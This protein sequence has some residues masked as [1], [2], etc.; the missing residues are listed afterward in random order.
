M[1]PKKRLSVFVVVCVLVMILFILFSTPLFTRTR[2]SFD[3][4][5]ANGNTFGQMGPMTPG[6]HDYFVINISATNTGS[7]QNPV[8]TAEIKW[9]PENTE[10]FQVI[11]RQNFK[12]F[13]DGFS[14]NYYIPIGENKYWVTAQN[15]RAVP[16]ATNDIVVNNIM[17]E[18]PQIEGIDFYVGR[19]ELKS[20]TFFPIDI[21]FNLQVKGLLG[22]QP[23][24]P[25][26]RYLGPSYIFL[27]SLLII[28][29]IFQL[30]FKNYLRQMPVSFGRKGISTLS[31]GRI[32]IVVSTAIL[33]LFSF[34]FLSLQA[35]TIKSYWDSYK[36]YI[37][38]GDLDKTYLGFYD[39]E[40][41]IG[42]L[43][44]EIPEKENIIVLVRGKPVYIMSEMAYNLYP[45]DIKF[46]NIS[47]KEGRAILEEIVGLNDP[48]VSDYQYVIAL[49]SED[50][51]MVPGLTLIENYTE[52]GGLI[53]TIK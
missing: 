5:P 15:G 11:N 48:A 50:T 41:F 18:L 36:K 26:N 19:V 12:I 34:Y 44:K 37:L 35:F 32:V 31:G 1:L 20:R 30:L 17:V 13:V 4:L 7:V 39:F 40:K 25:V 3:R 43:D 21:Y 38:S 23:T 46:V 28:A 53:Y 45:R 52:D 16:G 33:I 42:W 8:L 9:K 51:V 27:I 10:D 49:S 6:V 29:A 22:I 24:L 47:K 14:H 2:V